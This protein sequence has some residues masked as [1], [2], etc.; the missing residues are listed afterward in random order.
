MTD[1]EERTVPA[2]PVSCQLAGQVRNSKASPAAGKDAAVAAAAA[3]AATAGWKAGQWDVSSL[4]LG[5]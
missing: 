4:R 2:Q 3:A 1:V 5:L